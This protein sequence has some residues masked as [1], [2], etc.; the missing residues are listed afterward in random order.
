MVEL[1][2][3][4]PWDYVRVWIYIPSKVSEDSAFPFKIGEPCE[5]EIDTGGKRLVVKPIV[6]SAAYE[7]GWARR[8]RFE[9][10]E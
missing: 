6:A 2:L 10:K 8:N 1:N 4:Q 9:A 3:D 7:Q 5:V